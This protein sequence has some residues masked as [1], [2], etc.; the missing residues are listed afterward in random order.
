MKIFFLLLIFSLQ[1][2]AQTQNSPKEEIKEVAQEVKEDVKEKI[3]AIP[4]EV[5]NSASFRN[6]NNHS[7]MLG[8][9]ILTSWVPFKWSASYTYNFN[10]RWSLEGEFNRGS[11]GIGAFGFDAVSVKET[12]YSLLARKFIGNSFHFIIGAFK[13]DFHAELGSKYLEEM[14]DKTYS[15]FR[16]QGIGAVIGFGN[17]WQ[18]QRGFTLGIDWFRMNIPLIDK[19][20]ENEVIDNIND[21][22]DASFVKKWVRRVQNIPTFVLFG[23]NIGYS[24]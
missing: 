6:Q 15:D 23:L 21:D 19:K 16:V 18:W 2:F 11:W 13:S 8:Y 5:S 3:E 9:Q 22:S 12:R 4:Q 7:A 1:I 10:S 17:R 14:N 24:F 20:V